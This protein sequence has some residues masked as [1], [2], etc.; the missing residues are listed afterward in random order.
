M[1]VAFQLSF[2]QKIFITH[3]YDNYTHCY[4]R[5]LTSSFCSL[6]PSSVISSSK[7]FTTSP[8][9]IPSCEVMQ[10]HKTILK[11]LFE[12]YL[13]MIYFQIYILNYLQYNHVIIEIKLF[14]L[15]QL[16]PF[17]LFRNFLFQLF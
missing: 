17:C 14:R 3:I 15:F 5:I 11:L 16:S 6:I 12:H 1:L 9:R 4:L 8:N 2:D 7:L 10:V 13:T